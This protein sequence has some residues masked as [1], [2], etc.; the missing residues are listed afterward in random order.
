MVWGCNGWFLIW[1]IYFLELPL[2]PNKD[3]RKYTSKDF[4]S[5]ESASICLDNSSKLGPESPTSF[6]KTFSVEDFSSGAVVIDFLQ[7]ATPTNLN[8]AN[9]IKL[10]FF[11]SDC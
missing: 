6:F 11:K 9:R 10:D 7:P 2:R 8:S 5:S 4:F 1:C 3:V